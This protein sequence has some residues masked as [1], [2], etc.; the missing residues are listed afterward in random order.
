MNNEPHRGE[1][2]LL[3][4]PFDLNKSSCNDYVKVLKTP[5]NPQF[6]IVWNFLNIMVLRKVITE[7]YTE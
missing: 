3:K 6:T 5:Q 4:K 2:F 7:R 1:V